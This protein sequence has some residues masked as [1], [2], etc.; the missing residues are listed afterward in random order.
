MKSAL[1]KLLTVLGLG[2]TASVALADDAKIFPLSAS[3]KEE[4]GSCHVAYPPELMSQAS[5][6]AV[7]RGL[8]QHF[9]SDAS[10]DAAK[11]N[12]IGAYLEANAARRDKY[13]T[14]DAQGQ[15]L[16]RLTDGAWFR[17]KHRDGHD[18]I[19]VAVWKLQ[20]VKTAANCVA[21]HRGAERGD[22]SEGDIRIP[23][24]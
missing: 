16:L 2:L 5:W 18:G 24:S 23:R 20:S 7:M 21:C 13:A 12:E 3:Y 6:R 9:G 17:R 14:F 15:P 11:A 22:Y 10:L 19:T 8:D 4:C 1:S